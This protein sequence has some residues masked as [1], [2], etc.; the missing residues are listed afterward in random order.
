M[1]ISA[2]ATAIIEQMGGN[3]FFAMTGCKA[4]ASEAG[5]R[6]LLPR[7]AS[8]ANRFEVE[9]NAGLDLYEV[10]FYKYTAGRLNKKTFEWGEEKITNVREFSA[11]FAED[12]QQLFTEVTGLY[13]SL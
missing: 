9:Y 1:T 3:K 11:V 10:K 6:F 8:K 4:M 5:V 2:T 7:N 12:L 13:T